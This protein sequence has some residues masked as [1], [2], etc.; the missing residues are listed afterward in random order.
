MHLF[1]NSFNALRD[2]FP[3][4]F[5]K[6]FLRLLVLFDF[7]L[8]D[9]SDRLVGTREEVVGEEYLLCVLQILVVLDS[10]I[11]IKQQR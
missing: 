4:L 6:L 3:L 2:E 9:L 7:D 10:R 8:E 11:Q 1:V 5:E